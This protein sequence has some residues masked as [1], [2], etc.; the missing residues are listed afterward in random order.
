MVSTLLALKTL[1]LWELLLIVDVA[2]HQLILLWLSLEG[3]LPVHH[4]M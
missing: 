1:L 3:A 2:W 4:V